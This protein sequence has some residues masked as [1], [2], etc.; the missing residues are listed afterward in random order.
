[1]MSQNCDYLITPMNK[2]ADME[3]TKRCR[4][5][6]LRKPVAEFYEFRDNKTGKRYTRS[7]C[8]TCINQRRNERR[9]QQPTNEVI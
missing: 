3:A 4:L 2:G 1:M 8:I 5:C 7:T 6:D 9:N